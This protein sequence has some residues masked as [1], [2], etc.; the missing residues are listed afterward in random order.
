MNS[1]GVLNYLRGVHQG[2]LMISSGW[3]T[4][5][6]Y[7]VKKRLLEEI[8]NEAY[9][10]NS[11]PQNKAENLIKRLSSHNPL[12]SERYNP[13]LIS[14]FGLCSVEKI[15]SAIINEWLTKLSYGSADKIK[16]FWKNL[17]STFRSS[18][19]YKPFVELLDS[20]E[21]KLG[22]DMLPGNTVIILDD[23][24]RYNKD[25]IS[26][27]EILGFINNM[28][29][30]LHLKVIVI[31]N[32]ENFDSKGKLSHFKEKVVGKT[33]A[34]VP[35]RARIINNIV[36]E[37]IDEKNESFGSFMAQ[38]D[39]SG[40]MFTDSAFA[41]RNPQYRKALTNLRTIR[42]AVSHFY[43]FFNEAKKYFTDNGTEKELQ[44]ELLNF[45]WYT[46]LGISV[47]LKAN[48]I[49]CY[50]LRTLDQ[51]FFLERAEIDF[52]DNEQS[53]AEELFG[54]NIENTEIAEQKKKDKDDGI[55]A[56]HFY[57]L[58]LYSRGQ[59]P[60]SS[61]DILNFV[62]NGSSLNMADLVKAYIRDKAE[63][64]PEGNKA[65]ELLVKLTGKL[66]T[67]SDQEIESGIKQLLK[68]AGDG[69]FSN[70]SAFNQ[71]S[72]PL[73]MFSGLID[74]SK[75]EVAEVIIAGAK[76]WIVSHEIDARI[77]SQADMM[78]RMD[79]P[80]I[81]KNIGVEIV[82]ALDEKKKAQN[83]SAVEELIKQFSH[84]TK[85]FCKELCPQAF[86]HK[87]S[88]GVTYPMTNPILL[89]IKSDDVKAKV[90]NFTVAD[91][92][93][94]SMLLHNRYSI[95]N[96]GDLKALERPFWNLLY[97]ELQKG[98]K[99]TASRIYA[100]SAIIKPLKRFLN[101][102]NETDIADN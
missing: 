42:F 52:E 26:E 34:F 61:P 53:T 20:F 79:L 55:Y 19:K 93:A 78:A 1:E 81:Q 82:K 64:L 46:I 39:I 88:Y 95:E 10:Q 58:Y 12:V 80:D 29:E 23:L 73:L 96:I 101:I 70:L 45:G 43:V 94:L 60:I 97:D 62:V 68:Y 37:I 21:M 59:L 11:Q 30:N 66:E 54:S 38:D 57:E 67:M 13:V 75:E 36:K 27:E 5:K 24:E 50:D 3:G 89:M 83:N 56:R 99:A 15:E 102:K 4:G 2:A 6:T 28:T 33:L 22:I 72:A 77:D 86:T 9:V 69:A 44:N 41:L 74:K 8:S 7:Y 85:A 63:L 76:K 32:E 47:E 35:D 87:H 25:K 40:S 49:S 71:A 100:E 90:K 65:D 51:F 18:E 14:L 31:A 48:F 84:D 17:K 92:D 91:A 98:P 16:K